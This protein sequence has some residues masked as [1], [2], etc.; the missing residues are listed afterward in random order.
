MLN[1]RASISVSKFICVHRNE[2]IINNN[3]IALHPATLVI[4]CSIFQRYMKWYAI[5]TLTYLWNYMYNRIKCIMK[6]AFITS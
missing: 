5:Y 2:L 3:N 4:P 1:V 6:P